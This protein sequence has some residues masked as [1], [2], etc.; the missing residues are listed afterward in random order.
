MASNALCSL[1][2]SAQSEAELCVDR[3]VIYLAAAQSPIPVAR[4][5][6]VG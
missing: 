3:V 4:S 1:A 5:I 6:G 2:D